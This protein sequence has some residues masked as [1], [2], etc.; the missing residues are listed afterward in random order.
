MTLLFDLYVV[1]I[2]VLYY[3]FKTNTSMYLSI[4][5]RKI[6]VRHTGRDWPNIYFD[7]PEFT[8]SFNPKKRRNL[9]LFSYLGLRPFPMSMVSYSIFH[10]YTLMRVTTPL[11]FSNYTHF[12][13]FTTP[14]LHKIA[15]KYANL[16]EVAK[17]PRTL[18]FT[19]F[20]RLS[21]RIYGVTW[22]T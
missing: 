8:L 10:Y 20:Y 12:C 15:W 22:Y 7:K 19:G 1:F 4:L 21:S 11:C 6:P 9:C 18:D 5:H 2:F 17:M 13:Q 14:L 3:Y 16:C